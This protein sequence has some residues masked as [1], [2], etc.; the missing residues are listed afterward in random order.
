MLND[1]EIYMYVSRAKKGV[2][3]L[4]VLLPAI[5]VALALVTIWGLI[6]GLWAIMPDNW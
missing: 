4:S 2:W 6:V 5:G 3:T 1:P